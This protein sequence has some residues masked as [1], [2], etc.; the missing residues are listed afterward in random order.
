L[1]VWVI[2]WIERA[3]LVSGKTCVPVC[4]AGSEGRDRGK[5]DTGTERER[6]KEKEKDIGRAKQLTR[7]EC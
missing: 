4:I 6:E 7:G 5:N 2:H 3:E 1:G